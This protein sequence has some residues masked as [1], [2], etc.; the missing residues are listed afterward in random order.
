VEQSHQILEQKN[1][2]IQSNSEKTVNRLLELEQDKMQLTGELSKLTAQISELNIEVNRMQKA[3][4]ENKQRLIEVSQ[5]TDGYKQTSERLVVENAELQTKLDSLLVELKKERQLRKAV[6]TELGVSG[7]TTVELRANLAASQ[8]IVEDRKRKAEVDRL[9]MENEMEELKRTHVMEMNEMKDRLNKLKS[10]ST[11]V[12]Q[13]Q[14]NQ[15]EL[16]LNKE[17][18]IKLD[19]SLLLQQQKH[20]RQ[21]ALADEEKT[22]LQLQLHEVKDLLKTSKLNLSRTEADPSMSI[23]VNWTTCML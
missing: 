13:E 2:S 12:Y 4:I 16:D 7:E 20:E 5:N 19:K 18:Q 15:T 10:K 6:E 14:L 17:W 8:K 22:T 11:E 21:T 9:Q 23:N 1:M 3:E